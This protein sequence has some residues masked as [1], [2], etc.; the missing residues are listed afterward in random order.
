MY[1]VFHRVWWKPNSSWP[2]GLEPYGAARKTTIA[3]VRTEE[4][5]QAIAR[6]WNRTHEPGLYSRKAE[7]EE[8]R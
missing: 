5:A 3:L 2:N 8:V 6:E 4:E 7:Y 1:R